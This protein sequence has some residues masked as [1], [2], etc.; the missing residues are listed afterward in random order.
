[1]SVNR[2]L[3]YLGG[4]VIASLLLF[5]G[6]MLGGIAPA[7]FLP[8]P[9]VYAKATGR[10][11]GVITQKEIS[12]TANPFK[13][14][15]HVYLLD[16][17]FKAPEPPQRGELKPGPKQLH[18]AQIRVDD[19]VWGDQ[20][21]PQKSGIQPPVTI[22]VKYETTYPD[23]NGITGIAGSSGAIVPVDLGRGCGPGSNILS[24][25]LLFVLAD[26]VLAYLVMMV[27]LER[28]GRQE[29]I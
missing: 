1:M 8:P 7:K 9:L 5:P 15:D 27:V 24:G 12:A 20:D 16:Y 25:W 2:V 10:A 3:R 11:Y 17:K 29:D 21:N 13:V 26:L 18:T 4:L 19:T 28:F 23:I 6:L 22:T 14:G